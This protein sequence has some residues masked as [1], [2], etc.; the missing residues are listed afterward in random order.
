MV[1]QEAWIRQTQTITTSTLEPKGRQSQLQTVDQTTSHRIRQTTALVL[2]QAERGISSGIGASN[3]RR[4]IQHRAAVDCHL[5]QDGF[6]TH[7]AAGFAWYCACQVQLSWRYGHRNSRL[8]IRYSST[9]S[10]Q[11]AA[12]HSMVM[13]PQPKLNMCS[14]YPPKIERHF[15]SDALLSVRTPLPV[16]VISI[17][18]RIRINGSG[19]RQEFRIFQS[20]F[21]HPKVLA[22]LLCQEGA[23]S[24][25]LQSVF[26]CCFSYQTYGRSTWQS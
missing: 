6:W 16:L 25:V 5:L 7:P 8:Q 20:I 3:R 26:V 15:N 19:I 9:L 13:V 4:P 14:C 10:E 23:M 22:F 21:V 2:V 12:P 17:F 1:T 18:A 24:L 11:L